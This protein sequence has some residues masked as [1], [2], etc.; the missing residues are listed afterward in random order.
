MSHHQFVLH[1][2]QD[3]DMDPQ[4]SQPNVNLKKA[5]GEVWG[6]HNLGEI[7]KIKIN[8]I[9]RTR[10]EENKQTKKNNLQLDSMDSNFCRRGRTS[11]QG[12]FSPPLPLGRPYWLGPLVCGLLH[13]CCLLL[14]QQPAWICSNTHKFPGQTILCLKGGDWNS[15]DRNQ[16]ICLKEG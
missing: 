5:G 2:R 3:N 8:K 7:K 13:V 16:Y 11:G 14:Q 6:W 4:L 15:N 9:L 12:L 1:S 10:L